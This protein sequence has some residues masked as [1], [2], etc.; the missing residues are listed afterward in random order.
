MKFLSQL[1]ACVALAGFAGAAGAPA[2]AQSAPSQPGY[3]SFADVYRLTVGSPM[4]E[5]AAQTAEFQIKV[6]AFAPQ[7]L[8]QQASGPVFSIAAL[9]QPSNWLLL[10]SGLALA[11]WVARRRLGYSL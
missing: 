8:A 1:F 10:L 4:Q 7:P 9:P 6:A 11:G 5:A 3:F 2:V